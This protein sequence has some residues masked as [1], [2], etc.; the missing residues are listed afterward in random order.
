[1]LS[2]D[3]GFT[4]LAACENFRYRPATGLAAGAELASWDAKSFTSGASGTIYAGW[5]NVALTGSLLQVAMTHDAAT[6]LWSGAELEGIRLGSFTPP[7]FAECRAMA[8][9]VFG[10]W[11]APGFA[12][13]FPF[14]SVAGVEVDFA[15]LLGKTP[16]SVPQTVHGLTGALTDN[17]A[18]AADISNWHTYGA[19][20]YADHVDFYIDC[21]LTNT[22]TSA[23]VSGGVNR[24]AAADFVISFQAGGAFAGTPTD[25]STQYMY[26]DWIRAWTR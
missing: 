24:T 4:V 18:I 9:A 21:A 5:T 23:S 13:S 3:L 6:G 26:V 2:E 1:M 11:P 12:W 7:Y 22:I 25:L 20:V 19:A 17:A 8:P 14:G 15:E 10:M 16:L